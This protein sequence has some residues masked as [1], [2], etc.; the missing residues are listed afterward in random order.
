MSDTP[1][2]DTPMTR[3]YLTVVLLEAAVIVLL[4][5]VGRLYS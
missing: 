5:W 3:T 2:R 1:E 4:W